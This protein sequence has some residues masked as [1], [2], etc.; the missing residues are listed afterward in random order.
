M[1]LYVVMATRRNGESEFLE[2]YHDDALV[3]ARVDARRLAAMFE[4]DGLRYW[5]GEITEVPDDPE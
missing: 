3:D 5:I 1:S 4:G 2:M